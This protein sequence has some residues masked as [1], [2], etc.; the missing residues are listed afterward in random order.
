[1]RKLLLP[2]LLGLSLSA[3]AEA[4]PAGQED[5]AQ[6][7]VLYDAGKQAE[8]LA[9]LRAAADAG[10][11]PAMALLG[12][13]YINTAEG[14][15][16]RDVERGIALYTKA[17]EAGSAEAANNLAVHYAHGIA[18]PKDLTLS[19]QWFLRAAALGYV[20]AMTSVGLYH[21]T[22]T[23]VPAN[24]AEAQ[25]WYRRAAEA[26]DPQAMHNLGVSLLRGAAGPKDEAGARKWLEKAAAGGEPSAREVLAKL[27]AGEDPFARPAASE[28][29][30]ETPAESPAE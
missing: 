25:R 6:G 27:D 30:A 16:E 19:L 17:A 18:V 22:G 1:M 2:I 7:Q 13:L 20:P 14:L 11:V 4:P 12:W 28:S 5:F 26:G 24:P 21:E 23:V 10:H 9:R 3:F 15:P 8:G 29:P